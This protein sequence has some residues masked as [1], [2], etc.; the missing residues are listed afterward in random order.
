LSDLLVPG[1]GYV[2]ALLGPLSGSVDA[3][4]ASVTWEMEQT[5]S[6]LGGL[7]T[8]D[9][10]GD[11]AADVVIADFSVHRSAGAAY[12]QLGLVTGV[13]EASALPSFQ[14]D[15]T[16][17]LGWGVGTVSDWTG[18]GSDEIVIGVTSKTDDVTGAYGAVA[19]FVSDGLF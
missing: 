9:V 19:V 11:K 12:V 5:T 18:D 1:F 3:T 10:D 2:W 8:G 15:P 13:V 7:A 4:D 17:Y 6:A 16:D 14:G